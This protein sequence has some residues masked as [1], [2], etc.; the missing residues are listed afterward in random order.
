MGSKQRF[1]MQTFKL[2]YGSFYENGINS[3]AAKRIYSR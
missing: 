1:E 2:I 3:K